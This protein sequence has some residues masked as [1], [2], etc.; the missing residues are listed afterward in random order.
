MGSNSSKMSCLYLPAQSGKTRKIEEDIKLYKLLGQFYGDCINIFI[1]ANNKL[2]VHQ[3]TSRLTD[4]LSSSDED[5]ENANDTIKGTIFSWTS[6][7]KKTNISDGALAFEVLDDKVEMIIV[8][9]NSRRLEYL[10]LLINRL[11]SSKMFKKSMNIWI[12][13]ADRSIN[14]WSKPAFESILALPAVK[15]LTLVSATVDTIF[16]KYNRVHVLPHKITHP[17]CYRSLEDCKEK[18]IEFLSDSALDYIK[19]IVDRAPTGWLNG[20]RMF[21]PGDFTCAS[22]DAVADY[23][24]SKGFVVVVINGQRKQILVPGKDPISLI[25]YMTVND[26]VNL[27]PEFNQTLA[28]IYKENGFDSFPFAITG[29]LCVE[30]GVTFQCAPVENDHDGFLFDYAIIPPIDDACEAY[31]TM[32]RVFGNVGA[33]PDYK[34]C[35]IIS[36]ASNFQKIHH[37]EKIAKNIARIVEEYSLRDIG[38]DEL[39]WV[40]KDAGCTCSDCEKITKRAA[41]NPADFAYEYAEFS[42]IEEAS[43]YHGQ[44]KGSRGEKNDWAQDDNGFIRCSSDS[45]CVHSYEKLKHFCETKI[46]ANIGANNLKVGESHQRWYACYKDMKDKSSVVYIIRRLTRIK[47]PNMNP[48]WKGTV[49]KSGNPFD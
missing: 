30:R 28:R 9:A 1:S 41:S 38:K 17:P 31:Q 47:E 35:L 18:P 20:K 11:A 5:E 25:P 33:F 44:I 19:H 26:P 36:T 23:L 46:T 32:A 27:P 37:Q 48:P 45:V 43:A 15:R 10:S 13:E 14:L 24:Y 16:K 42:S 12:D 40:A 2:L 39:N 21:T 8:C 7:S 22:H 6:G 34:P 4:S 49:K 29:F 3:T